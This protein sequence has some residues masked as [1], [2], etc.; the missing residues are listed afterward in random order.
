[1][2]QVATADQ[3]LAHGD[4]I[5]Y[6]LVDD[7]SH[8]FL[9]SSSGQITVNAANIDYETSSGHQ[10]HV[11]VRATD[12]G[13]LHVDQVLTISVNDVNEAPT[14]MTMASHSV[15]ENATTGATVGTVVA[16]DPD[17]SHGDTLSYSLTN[18][19]SG[20]FAINAT[21]GVVTVANATGFDFESNPTHQITVRVTDGASHTLDQNFTINLTDV[22][23][24]ATQAVLNGG[25][26]FVSGG[27]T[28]D[29]LLTG[30]QPGALLAVMGT[31]DPDAS[32][33]FLHANQYQ[34]T[35]STGLSALGLSQSDFE[36]VELP[37]DDGNMEVVL[38]LKSTAGTNFG[39]TAAPFAL[40][41]QIDADGIAG[42]VVVIRQQRRSVSS[43]V[44]TSCNS[45]PSTASTVS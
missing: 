14:G 27:Q 9:I 16:A 19:D 29:A 38:R 43:P 26:K 39:A 5:T 42:F 45:N 3:D 33:T 36:F 35:G 31:N 7:D 28:Y 2:G 44:T 4:T 41:I 20:H 22:N 13:G 8:N 23:E 37:G 17:S 32:P 6:S 1:V 25:Q 34:I 11:T 10:R 40:T 30:N 24:P 21:T 12:S 18:N 15:A